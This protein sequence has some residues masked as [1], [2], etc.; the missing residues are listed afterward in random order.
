MKKKII[1]LSSVSCGGAERM[2]ILYAK[3]LQQG[4]YDCECWIYKNSRR[5]DIPIL[6]FIPDNLPYKI[7]ESRDCLFI[8]YYFLYLRL[9]DANIIFTS[10]PISAKRL[11]K[12][13]KYGLITQKVIFRDFLMP[14]N[15]L[16]EPNPSEGVLF[17]FADAIVAQTDEMKSEMELYYNLPKDKI[18]V[19][20]NPI[21]KCLINEGIKEKCSEID[22]SYVNYIAIN[23]ITEQKDI[24]TMLIA[25]SIVKKT[26]HK[27]RLYIC[28]DCNKQE[29]LLKLKML[30]RE[31]QLE[32]DVFLLG[33]QSNPFK[34][35]YRCNVFVLSS[36]Y[37]GLP[38]S[39]LE[40]MYLGI[41][42]AVT[43]SIPF[44]KQVVK[45]GI[46]GYTADISNPE[47]LAQAMLKASKLS[48]KDKFVDICQSE[49][50]IVDLFERF[51]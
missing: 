37:E 41:P 51:S 35:L 45:E 3:I 34:Y 2:T 6:D 11:L 48:I 50:E 32:K 38:N 15:R 22:P 25:F 44:I 9:S 24:P 4:G 16:S 27:S 33:Q 1:F 20:Y 17:S 29:Y 8:L 23:R 42:V 21:D 43:H 10:Q 18:D 39:M 7:I 40:A 49:D 31:L 47:N 12:L 46:N 13:K 36:L 19:I 26:N 5:Q 28:G 30:I 14:S